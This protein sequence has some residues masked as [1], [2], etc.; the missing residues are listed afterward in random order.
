MFEDYWAFLADKSNQLTL[1]WLGGGL[2]VLAGGVW[3][4]VTFYWKPKKPSGDKSP[5]SNIEILADRSG[6]GAGG[7]VTI[8]QRMGLSGPALVAVLLA[9]FGT[10]LLAGAFV[11]NKITASNCSVATG[12]DIQGTTINVKSDNGC[13]AK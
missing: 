10:V 7:D 8:D 13:D 4:A 5:Q 2:V 11:G 12:G 3:T 6:I 1:T 9:G